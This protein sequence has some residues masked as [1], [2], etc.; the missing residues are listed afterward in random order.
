MA[1][2][3]GNLASLPSRVR[4]LSRFSRDICNVSK[5]ACLSGNI[6]RLANL[7]CHIPRFADL[8]GSTNTTNKQSA[9]VDRAAPQRLTIVDLERNVAITYEVQRRI[10]DKKGNRFKPDMIGVTANAACSIALRNAIL[11]GVPKAFWSDMYEAARRTAIGDNQTLANRRARALG[12]LQKYGATPEMV[13]K[14]LGIQGEEDITLEHLTVLFGITTSL[15]EGE[16]TV[17]QAFAEQAS[18]EG[19]A[20]PQPQSKSARAAAPAASQ[21]DADG[22]IPQPSSEGAQQN[23]APAQRTSRRAAPQPAAREPGGDDEAFEQ[24][25]PATGAPASDSVMRILKTKMEQA[26]LGEADLRKRFNFG[27]DGVTTA[28]YNEVVAWIED[29]MAGA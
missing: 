21:A 2:R 20:V 16:A 29:P 6:H 25:T 19:A 1:S 7:A 22:V 23:A 26:A 27:Y 28:N 13:F 8:A 10:V 15:K 14:L 17:E 18:A 3:L 9:D 4:N 12:V 24:G 5:L 11:K